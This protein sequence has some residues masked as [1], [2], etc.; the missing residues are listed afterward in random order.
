MDTL[1]TY[2]L[3]VRPWSFSASMMPVLLGNALAYPPLRA[4]S[5][6]VLF[7]TCLSTLCVHAAAN[8]FNTYVDLSSS[9]ITE[10]HSFRY[11]DYVHGVDTAPTTNKRD[12][13]DDTIADNVDDRTLIEGLLRPND[14]VRLGLILY[15]IGTMAF[16]CLT[17]FSPAKEPY[18]AFIFFGALPL[19]FLYT[20][21][22]GESYFLIGNTRRSISSRLCP[23][24][25]VSLERHWMRD[26][27]RIAI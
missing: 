1:E 22:I 4:M 24:W 11:Y 12:D 26:T 2:L 7:L 23:C 18:L 10:R 3:A 9:I 6:L 14:V 17:H 5:F 19:S 21:G 8:L 13:G 20:G 27:V 25:W 16:I 15:A